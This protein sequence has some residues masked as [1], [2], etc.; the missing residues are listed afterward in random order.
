MA[1]FDD[2]KKMLIRHN[3]QKYGHLILAETVFVNFLKC[4]SAQK[5]CAMNLTIETNLEDAVFFGVEQQKKTFSKNC[6]Y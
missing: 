2:K 3:K 5:V 6:L 1:T 4:N